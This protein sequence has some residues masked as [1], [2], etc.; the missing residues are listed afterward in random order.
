M[1]MNKYIL[2]AL[3]GASLGLT[4]ACNSPTAPPDASASAPAPPLAGAVDTR[5]IGGG[6]DL[7][8]IKRIAVQAD[9]SWKVI[10]QTR[11]TRAQQRAMNAEKSAWQARV[12]RGENAQLRP[13]SS[14]AFCPWQDLWL[15]DD[16][17]QEGNRVC[18]SNNSETQLI[19][20]P[21]DPEP[22]VFQTKSWWGGERSFRLWGNFWTDS[23]G[24]LGTYTV[25]NGG[26]LQRNDN[27]GTPY[28]SF[29]TVF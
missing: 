10:A 25:A 13:M 12:S 24:S 4:V 17:N 5:S 3:V 9:G 16:V 22:N 11:V 2:V 18:V 15:N 21:E 26:P 27:S 19:S 14:A 6:G 23:C 7:V 20:C 1:M 8:T 28:P 29:A